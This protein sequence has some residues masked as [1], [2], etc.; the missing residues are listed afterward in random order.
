[1]NKSDL[2]IKREYKRRSNAPAAIV[3]KRAAENNPNWDYELIENT[4]CIFVDNSEGHEYVSIFVWHDIYRI[5][6][7]ADAYVCGRSMLQDLA[8]RIRQSFRAYD[9]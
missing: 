5:H 1:M 9:Y 7:D 6:I 2:E 4:H 8:R 3:A